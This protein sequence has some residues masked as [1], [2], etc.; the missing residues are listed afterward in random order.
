V[1]AQPEAVVRLM[2]VTK[3]FGKD[4]V[5]ALQEVDLEIG[6]GEFVSLI[7]PSGCGKST[8]LRVVGDLIQ[9]SSGTVEVNGKSAAQARAD[10][11][12]G[13]VFQD[14]VLFEWRTVA[15][16][17]GLPLELAGWSREKRRE[18]VQE[19]L[20]LVELAGFEAHH[21]WQLSG[22]MQQR[23]SIARALS[24]DPAL[25]LMDEPFGALDEMTRERLN[26]ELLRIWEA[27]RSTVI[28]VTHSISEAV[29]LST[30]VVVMSPRPGRITGIVDVDLPQPRTTRTREE[31]RFA[32]LIR[33]VRQ[34]LRAGGGFE[35]DE[36]VDEEQLIVAEEGL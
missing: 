34:T 33:E 10:R 1:S 31:P 12:Y 4:G 8:L 24:F 27:S 32:E 7:G 14:S 25:L 36:E 20:D 22:G 2:D 28:F 11:D 18:R 16:N 3:Q 23:V 15:R 30:R 19:M 5:T 21:P 6:P 13:I 17:I 9:P 26:L 29:F 35:V